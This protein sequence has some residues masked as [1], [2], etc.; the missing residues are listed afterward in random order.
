MTATTET[1]HKKTLLGVV[2]GI[3]SVGM[4]SILNLALVPIIT[5]K[6]GLA[7]FGVYVLLLGMYETSQYLDFGLNSA[8][9]QELAS[10]DEGSPAYIDKLWQGHTLFVLLSSIV[11]IICVLAGVGLFYFIP[12]PPGGQ[13]VYASCIG[14]IVIESWLCRYYSYFNSVMQSKHAQYWVDANLALYSNISLVGGVS[15]LMLGWGLVGVI[16]ARVVGVLIA[17]L[18]A[19]VLAFRTEPLLRQ[20][21]WVMHRD[22]A[23]TF[24]KTGYYGTLMNL[25]IIIS[26]KVDSYVIALF[27]PL[28]VVGLFEV[29]LRIFGPLNNLCVRLGGSF[30]PLFTRYMSQQ[31]LPEARALLSRATAFFGSLVVLGCSIALPYTMPIINWF[32]NEGLA[33]G[34]VLSL[35]AVNA[36]ILLSG[37][38]IIPSNYCLFSA[39]RFDF[40]VRTGLI[41]AG[42]NVALSFLLAWLVLRVASDAWVPLAVAFGT[43]IPQGL[44]HQVWLIP[45]ALQEIELPWRTFALAVA[46]VSGQLILVQAVVLAVL[47]QVPFVRVWRAGLNQAIASVCAAVVHHPVMLP[48][49][50]APCLILACTGVVALLWANTT[51]EERHRVWAQCRAKIGLAPEIETSS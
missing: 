7:W 48:S 6:M 12:P 18:T 46:K 24:L 15:A 42:I 33:Q 1:H 45:R 21:R 31:R 20:F 27:A 47:T 29:T 4:R 34:P 8:V 17:F 44:Q 38:L 25:G 22:Y 14:L 36:L 40:L 11:L 10:E 23:T 49:F 16:G 35:V 50:V 3:G 13:A 19:L 28:E 32:S 43:L 2:T 30:F 37:S 26:H 5:H 51:A 41:T 39:R 9:I